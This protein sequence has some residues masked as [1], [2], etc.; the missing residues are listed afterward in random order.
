M[1][2]LILRCCKTLT[3]FSRD[4]RCIVIIITAFSGRAA[5]SHLWWMCSLGSVITWRHCYLGCLL[6]AFESIRHL[7]Q[8]KF[9]LKVRT[10]NN[11]VAILYFNVWKKAMMTPGSSS[12]PRHS[13]SVKHLSIYLY[14]IKHESSR[15]CGF[16]Q[17][18]LW[19]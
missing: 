10:K 9:V 19:K 8:Q 15:I 2:N 16:R 14:Y 18:D 7:Y 3:S 17:D 1:L 4:D 5:L 6:E 11:Y 12:Y 13:Y